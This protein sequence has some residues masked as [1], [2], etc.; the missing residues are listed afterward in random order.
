MT[1]YVDQTYLHKY[2]N[3]SKCWNY[4][5]KLIKIKKTP[6]YNV[7]PISFNR[8]QIMSAS[9]FALFARRCNASPPLVEYFNTLLAVRFIRLLLKMFNTTIGN[10]FVTNGDIIHTEITLFGFPENSETWLLN[11]RCL[12]VYQCWHALLQPQYYTSKMNFFN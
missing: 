10:F 6:G 2:A 3:V 1:V 5:C 11:L 4:Q 9:P 8:M 7:H 12:A